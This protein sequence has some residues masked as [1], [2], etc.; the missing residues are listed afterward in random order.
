[1][2]AFGEKLR[3]Q[4]E[5]RGITLEAISSTTK[6]STRML[7]ALEEEHFDQLP[8]GVFNKGFIR[9]YARQVGLNEEEAINDYLAALHALQIQAQ[10]IL[11]DLRAGKSP[12]PAPE[13]TNH[14]QEPA[15]EGDAVADKSVQHEGGAAVIAADTDS[16]ADDRR[17]QL[18]RTHDRSNE[19]RRNEERRNEDGHD[20]DSEERW[21]IEN[22]PAADLLLSAQETENEYSRKA[23]MKT[24]ATGRFGEADSQKS[25]TR[26]PWGALAAAL[27][28]ICAGIFFWNFHRHSRSMHNAQAAMSQTPPTA[29]MPVS[30]PSSASHP[31]NAKLDGTTAKKPLKTSVAKPQSQGTHTSAPAPNAHSA[32]TEN[33]GTSSAE[34]LSASAAAPPSK[35]VGSSSAASNP[36]PFTLLIRAEKTSWVSITADGNVVAEETLIAPAEKRV[37]A[38]DQIV[39]KTGNAAGISFL[40]NAKEIPSQGKDGEVKTYTFNASGIEVSGNSQAP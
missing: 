29:E 18:R 35:A 39:V 31:L 38:S 7:R 25:P 16:I 13:L 26:V 11:P 21:Q 14:L 6:I 19:D 3:R 33:A 37:R 20:E 22:R 8:G 27:L 30:E 2:E 34:K 17:H 4:R 40:L 15:R 5:Q 23:G 9:A 28:V 1:M 24:F 36:A 12:R 32:A 10:R